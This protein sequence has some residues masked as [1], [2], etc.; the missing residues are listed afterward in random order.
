MLLTFGLGF[1]N[2]ALTVTDY[3]KFDKITNIERVTPTNVTFPA[4]TICNYNRYTKDLYVNG[5]FI[6]SSNLTVSNEKNSIIKNFINWNL[7]RFYS[8]ELDSYLN[9]SEHL[10]YFKIPDLLDCLR[11]NGVTNKSLDLLTAKHTEDYLTI[12]LYNSYNETIDANEYFNMKFVNK[13]RVFIANN[14]LNSFDILDSFKLDTGTRYDFDIVKDSIEI[15]LSE[16]YN[17]CKESS[18]AKP[19]HQAI[20][21]D[22]CLYR[23]IRNKYNC[24]FLF[25][26]YSFDGYKQCNKSITFYKN[27]FSSVCSKECPLESCHSEKYIPILKVDERPG[28]TYLRFALYD[29]SN[30]NITQIPKTDLFTFINNIGGGLGLFMG[31]AF[32]N[33][34]E[35]LQFITEVI[36]IVF[37]Y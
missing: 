30:L 28:N 18:V 24:S 33:I 6:N 19:Y 17:Q 7:T 37:N 23:E 34:I 16:P 25:T 11:F 29:L 9:V 8:Y 26:L 20:C 21:I 10:D 32:P 1:W 22:T 12:D 36:L 14:S 2:I 13:L 5:N 27:E 31:I 15:K 3:Y 4:I 35:F